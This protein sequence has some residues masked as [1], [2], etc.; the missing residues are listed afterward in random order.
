MDVL[1]FAHAEEIRS[2]VTF[3]DVS[4]LRV[5]TKKGEFIASPVLFCIK[6][7]EFVADFYPNGHEAAEVGQSS[8]YLRRSS[9]RAESILVKFEFARGPAVPNI[10]A[11]DEYMEFGL[12]PNLIKGYR[13]WTSVEELKNKDDT[14]EINIHAIVRHGNYGATDSDV[15]AIVAHSLVADLAA[16]LES[17]VGADVTLQLSDCERRVHKS[18][19]MARSPVFR[20]MFENNMVESRTGKVHMPDVDGSVIDL[21]LKFLYTDALPE[22]DVNLD[23]LC[24]SLLPV[25]SK[26]E[27]TGLTKY[28]CKI[29][30]KAISV[31]N[32]VDLLK[33]ADAVS[34]TELRD[35][36]LKFISS[37]QAT[38]IAVQDTDAFD[39]LDN[40]LMKEL[41]AAVTGNRGSKRQRSDKFEFP[42]GT[43]WQKLTAAQLRRACAERDLPT[44]GNKATMCARLPS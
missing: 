20:Q 37:S 32:A 8:I 13:N 35:A 10:S 11:S 6:G 21:F 3:K 9:G 4:A 43:V 29:L 39:S 24:R 36:A 34:V 38:L 12:Q 22:G 26:Y 16:S 14:L 40:D 7:H 41:F 25:A 27:I 30:V 23:K 2:S 18:V 15:G 28:C 19:L 1:G 5:M 17:G 31:E 44:G 42:E 33:I